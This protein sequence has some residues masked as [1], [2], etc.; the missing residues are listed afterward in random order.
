MF[1][2]ITKLHSIDNAFTQTVKTRL[3]HFFGITFLATLLPVIIFGTIGYIIDLMLIN[4]KPIGFIISI[5]I[6]FPVSQYTVMKVMRKYANN[7][8]AKRKNGK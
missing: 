4:E 1:K 3:F 7:Q 5:C 6:A 2:N 8:L